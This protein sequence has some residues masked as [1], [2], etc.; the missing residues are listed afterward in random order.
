MN[1]QQ[2]TDRF[3]PFHAKLY[4]VAYVLLNN[5]ADAEDILQDTYHKLW[6]KRDELSN[7]GQPEAFCITL[8]RNLCIDFLR[9]PRRRTDD[10]TDDVL[11][12]KTDHTTPESELVSNENLQYIENMIY[13][14]PEKQRIV[15]QMRVY[16]ECS[17]EEIQAATGESA[18]NIRVLLS[19][20][21]N[22]L[23]DLINT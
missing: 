9:S 7:I 2:F 8:V 23:R 11:Q 13:R 21:R 6:N 22:T 17:S 10:E 14:L 19:R 5:A 16:G 3:Y 15:M 18:A 20:A 12:K 1:A 4:R